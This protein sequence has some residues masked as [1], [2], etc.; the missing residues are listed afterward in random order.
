MTGLTI[1]QSDLASYARCAQQKKLRDLQKVGMLPKAPEQLS[2]T[3]YGSVIHHA[4]HAMEMAKLQGSADPLA[5]ARA[6]F[7]YY[8]DPANIGSICDPVTIW[9]A[10]DTRSGMLRKG[11]AT[12]DLYWEHLQKDVSKVLGLEVSFTLPYELDGETH[13]IHGTM[14]RLSVRKMSSTNVLN[15]ED[16][17]SGKDYEKLRWNLQFTIYSWA[18]TQRAFW[19]QWHE[20]DPGIYDRLRLLPRRGT[21]ISLQSGVKRSD[22]GFRGMQDYLRMDAALREYVKA[23]R[24]DIY[25][26]SIVGAVCEYCPYREGICGG[27]AVPEE[28]HGRSS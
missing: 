11:L 14:D 12:L 3:A 23:V 1:R 6:T 26:L 19:D 5:T 28:T 16:F 15:I 7:E 2:R 22:A 27:V 25:P 4:A 10:R 17:K 21:W 9:C 13:T 24:A 18:T 8:W 20:F